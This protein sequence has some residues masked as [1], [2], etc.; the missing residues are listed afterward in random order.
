MTLF[1]LGGVSH[2]DGEPERARTELLIGIV[3]P[4]TSLAIGLACLGV[5]AA[6]GWSFG[7]SP[8]PRR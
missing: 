5:A 6:L 7:A 2:I 8:S 3:G 1:A 4:L